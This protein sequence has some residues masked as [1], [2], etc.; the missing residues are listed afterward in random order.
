MIPGFYD[1]LAP[2]TPEQDAALRK[3]A[4]NYDLKKAAQ[5]IGITRFISDD[6]YTVLKMLRTGTSINLDGIWGGNMFAGGSGAI[7]P[8][9][10]TSKHGFRYQA[11][12]SGD[13]IAA[14]LR[15]Y[16]DQ[17]GYKDVDMHIVG[18]V[19][20]AKRD[21]DNDLF[22]S[23]NFAQSIFGVGTGVAFSGGGGGYWPAY[24]FSGR[25]TTIDLPI[26][27]AR[28]GAGGNAHAANEWYAIEGAGKQ[29]GM[30][31]SEK[32]IATALYTYAGL[33]GTPATAPT[34]AAK[35]QA[36]GSGS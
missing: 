6:P 22:R 3:A 26:N 21:N 34:E 12:M 23:N 18:D 9:K 19:P 31:S 20:W 2:V 4:E 8:N 35:A 28:G 11:N 17:L 14:K 27:T 1:D 7:L 16:L 32:L 24:V 15:K 33:N 29:L 13:D 5:N 30:A 36:A 25:G 10:I